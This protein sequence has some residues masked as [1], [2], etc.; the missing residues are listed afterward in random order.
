MKILI[1]VVGLFAVCCCLKASG[2]PIASNVV[3]ALVILWGMLAL[4]VVAIEC[5]RRDTDWET[6]EEDTDTWMD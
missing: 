5:L 1:S 6:S 4:Y 3:D 2:D